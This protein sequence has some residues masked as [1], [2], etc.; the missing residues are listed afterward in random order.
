M[1]SSAPIPRDA[2]FSHLRVQVD[3]WWLHYIE[4][5]GLTLNSDIS[6]FIKIMDTAARKKFPVH[7]RRMKCFTHTQKGDT[8]S[9]LREIV[10][11]IKLA[12]W[13]SFNEE[14]AA[15]HIFMATT[16]DEVAKSIVN[17]KVMLSKK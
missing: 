11:S 12:E 3:A 16:T 1:Q 4:Y 9:H 13:S 7:G 8:M 17:Q 14:A 5:V 6:H 2:V 10:E 15:M